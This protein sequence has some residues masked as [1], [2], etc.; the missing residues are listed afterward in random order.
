MATLYVVATPIG[1]LED[2]TLRA[3]RVLSTVSLVACEDTRTT[4]RLLNA[5]GIKARRLVSYNEHNKKTRLPA[6]LRA[7][8][9]N[10]VAVVSE[11][12]TPTISDPGAD[13]V[14]R[15]AERG[16][17]VVPVPGPS[18]IMTALVVSG[19]STRRF[20]YLGFLP[21]RKRDRAALLRRLAV[22]PETLVIYEAPHRLQKSLL[23]LEQALGDRRIAVCREVTKLHEEVF[24]GTLS[25]AIEHFSAPR[26]EFT[27]VLEGA[28]A[29]ATAA[30]VDLDFALS[31]LRAQGISARDAVREVVDLTGA[32]RREVYQRWLELQGRLD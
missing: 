11:A 10:D 6:I 27:L 29:S 16:F 28:E 26:G 30:E 9:S 20:I 31:R 4:R 21:R 23:E 5:H 19:I 25:Q 14:A 12:G 22:L 7:L 3:L 15:C 18:A 24:R 32:S 13:L 8:T 1:N 17:P 2:I